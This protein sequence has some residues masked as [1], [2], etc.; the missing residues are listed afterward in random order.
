MINI[1]GYKIEQKIDENTTS[2]IYRG[3]KSTT[4]ESFILK[5]PRS[6][7]PTPAEIERL[8]YEH[9]IISHLNLDGIVK[10]YGI[11]YFD[12][13][14]ALVL[15]DFKAVTLSTFIHNTKIDLNTF[16]TIAAKLAETLDDLQQNNIIHRNITPE[17]ILINPKTMQVK[18]TNFGI[19]SLITQKKYDVYE[20]DLLHETLVYI[21][22]EQTGRM[23]RPVDFRSDLYS[24]GVIF[25]E[26]LTR[27]PPF[28]ST[29]PMELIHSHIAKIPVPPGAINKEV[30]QAVSDIVMKLLA[31][32]AEARYRSG[33]GL[34]ADLEYC[35]IHLADGGKIENFVPGRTDS[36]D[37]FQISPKLYGRENEM[38]TLIPAFETAGKGSQ[39]I[40]FI[41]GAEGIGK[42]GIINEIEKNILRENVYFLKVTFE[43][44]KKEIP[45][46]AVIQAFQKLI[47]RLLISSEDIIKFWRTKFLTEIGPYINVII[48]VIPDFEFIAGKQGQGN[49]ASLHPHQLLKEAFKKLIAVFG[50]K[51]SP[52]VIF[53]DDLQ[54]LDNAS[55]NLFKSLLGENKTNF[56]LVIGTY[57]STAINSSHPLTIIFEELKKSFGTINNITLNPLNKLDIKQLLEDSFSP[58]AAEDIYFLTELI[59]T[60]TAGNPA[61][62]HQLLNSLYEEKLILLNTGSGIWEWDI[63][64]IKNSYVSEITVEAIIEKI[65]KFP[66]ATH[67]VLKMAACLGPEFYFKDLVTVYGKSEVETFSDLSRAVNEG[68]IILSEEKNKFRNEM[69]HQ[70]AYS[71]VPE[72]NRPTLHYK[73]G[74]LLLQNI[75]EEDVKDKVFDIVGHFSQGIN[76][77]DQRDK[78]KLAEL[79]LAA[80][81][82]VKADARYDLALKHFN[83]GMTFLSKNSWRYE[84]ELTFS[85]YVERGECEY[86]SENFIEA[87]EYFAL[88]LKNSKSDYEKNLVNNI[89]SNL[90]AK[91]LISGGADNSAGASGSPNLPDKGSGKSDGSFGLDYNTVMKA[92]QTL[93]AEILLDKLLDK[94]M[95][96]VIENAGAQRGVLL[97]KSKDS[98]RI[99]AERSV[100]ID[101]TKVLESI[102]LEDSTTIS[103]AI[104]NYV[105][106]TQQDVVLND[107]I[108]EG[109]FTS[110]P[111]IR[112]NRPKSILCT[113]IIKQSQLVGILY[114][115]NNLTIGAFTSDRL[116]ILRLLSSQASISLENARLYDEMKELNSSLEQHKNHLE[117]MVEERTMQL[118]ET[119]QK[120]LDSAHKAGMAEIATGVLHNV[121]NILNSLS[122]SGELIIKT[123]EKSELGGLQQA[124]QLLSKNIDNIADFI[125]NSPKGQKLPQFYLSVGD[126]LTEEHQKLKTEATSL[127][128]KIAL[129][130]NVVATQQSYARAGFLIEKVNL[131]D[132]VENALSIQLGSLLRHG[133][134]VHKKINNVPD[135]S[136][137]KSKLLHVLMNIIKNGKEAMEENDLENKI[138]TIEIN[139]HNNELVYLKIS[140][141]GK[142]ILAENLNRIFNHGFTTKDDGHGFGLHTC[143]NAMTEMGG[144]IKVFSD[145]PGKGATFVLAF[146]L[147]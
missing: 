94:L 20:P 132:I 92:F 14:A 47:N 89:V 77:I 10:T 133:I 56:L 106:R 102:R 98:L 91:K 32:N 101:G 129:T 60:E 131:G 141:N 83:A 74:R 111:Y 119:Q 61:L 37:K 71:L 143:A 1:P 140:D 134:Q 38:L 78:N 8:N 144:G 69:Y 73:I 35:R 68:V 24:I 2:I 39:E 49:S 57:V 51:E 23:N 128:E 135:I 66:G 113:P 40:V 97:L 72:H 17:N 4:R 112:D 65:S 146:P 3:F 29:E 52:F 139:S 48:G 100:N 31:K 84:H 105:A 46:Y 22:P 70:A 81:K 116:E 124:N 44:D 118:K 5:A 9:D 142:G 75:R 63:N 12:N 16:F 67:N 86:L 95:K 115:E 25:Y 33:K 13:T 82:K 137:Q 130:K 85:L 80:G 99:E 121:G 117:E 6:K 88:A 114:L 110:D 53:L 7:K 93:S 136:V 34:K 107:A 109:M 145:G 104:I 27:V 125:V 18:L 96:I 123:L 15:E 11:E 36:S 26:M 87:E 103:H 127:I 122:V 147:K 79:N 19:S 21:S 64:R 120:F 42:T 62:I 138:L 28:R 76:F 90:T 43:Q 55:L 45:Y 126:M 41:N 50:A 108:N 59:F 58:A 54:W 30:P